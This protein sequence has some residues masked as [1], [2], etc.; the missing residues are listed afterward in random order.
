MYMVTFPYLLL[1]IFFFRGVA[2]PGAGEGLRYLFFPDFDRLLE[3]YVRAR[4]T[5]TCMQQ[6]YAP[7]WAYIWLHKSSD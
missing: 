6:A 1:V 5:L 4:R 2:L 7:F 3:P